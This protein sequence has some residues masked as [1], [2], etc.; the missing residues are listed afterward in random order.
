VPRLIVLNGPP[1]CGKSTLARMYADEHP[2]VLNLDID[3]LRG[4]LGR[5]RDDPHTAGLLAREIAF[6]AARTHLAAGHDVVIPQFL[7]RLAFLEQLEQLADEAGAAFHEIVLLD[8]KENALRRFAER[9]QEAAGSAA[10]AAHQLA[11][12]RG[13]PGELSAM[14]D[15]L[16]FVIASR[17]TAKVVP[18]RSGQVRQAYQAFLGSLT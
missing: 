13:G 10:A 1:G 4:A 2:L 17:R 9:G 5:W 7:G 12:H 6:A 16:A 18:T 3:Q 8:S 15:R 14:Y 11:D